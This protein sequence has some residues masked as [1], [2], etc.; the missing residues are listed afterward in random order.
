M[1]FPGTS[2]RFGSALITTPYCETCKAETYHRRGACI[3]CNSVKPVVRPA[4]QSNAKMRKP[5][6]K[7]ELAQLCAKMSF[8][9]LQKHYRAAHRVVRKWLDIHG[10]RTKG[11]RA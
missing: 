7:A 6:P 4:P 1:T 11:M 2:L 9:Q 5:P 3:H 10:L 8:Q